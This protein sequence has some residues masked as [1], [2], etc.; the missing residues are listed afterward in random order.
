MLSGS[1]ASPIFIRRPLPASMR[2]ATT[3]SGALRRA[4]Y[5][6][7]RSALIAIGITV[8]PTSASCSRLSVPSPS[9]SDRTEIVPLSA[10][11]T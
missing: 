1:G 2:K 3:A 4:A 10:L 9:S 5:R 11:L 7:R 8:P 6:K